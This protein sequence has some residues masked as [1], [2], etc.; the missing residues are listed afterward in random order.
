MTRIKICGLRRPQDV[1]AANA[2]RPDFVG[3]VFAPS[4]RQVSDRQAAAL[5]ASLNPGIM[6]VGVFVDDDPARIARLY[7]QGVVQMAQLH[8]NEG[9]AM[10]DELKALCPS[11]AVIKAYY[12]LPAADYLLLDNA[13]PGSGIPLAASKSD[14]AL[15]KRRIEASSLPVFL[16][17]GIDEGNIGQALA[18]K[19]FCVDVS[20]GAETDG[21]KDPLKMARLVKACRCGRCESPMRKEQ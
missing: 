14:S 13:Q 7:E 19:P 20:S 5:A 17:G 8:G 18:L 12:P 9:A 4:S 2:A 16:A 6:A 21:M 10:L 3:F 1:E 11:I 15:L